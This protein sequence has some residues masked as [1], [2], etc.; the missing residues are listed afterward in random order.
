MQP[1]FELYAFCVVWPWAIRLCRARGKVRKSNLS[2]S[3]SYLPPSVDIDSRG[4]R[5]QFRKTKTPKQRPPQAHSIVPSFNNG[6][7]SNK[8]LAEQH[9]RFVAS[10]IFRSN[11]RLA[12][13][14]TRKG[15][16]DRVEL[17]RA[18]A[19]SLPTHEIGHLGVS[20][21]KAVGRSHKV[22]DSV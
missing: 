3:C 6:R 20:V 5:P 8:S 7:R 15:R 18:P 10:H 13:R 9:K 14:P 22:L 4:K 1:H 17:M 21:G 12:P 2:G 11:A 16:L 19:R